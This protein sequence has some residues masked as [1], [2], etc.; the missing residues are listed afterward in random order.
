[1]EGFRAAH[2]IGCAHLD[3]ERLH[4]THSGEFSAAWHRLDHT[5]PKSFSPSSASATL[6]AWFSTRDDPGRIRR[7]PEQQ[8]E[9]RRPTAARAPARGQPPARP[10]TSTC[11]RSPSTPPSAPM[12][13]DGKAECRAR[14]APAAGRSTACGPRS[15]SRAPIRTIARRRRSRSMPGSQQRARTTS[16]PAWRTACTNTSGASTAA[17]AGSTTMS[18]SAHARAGARARRGAGRATNY[19]GGRRDQRGGAARDRRDVPAGHRRDVH[20]ALSHAA[21][22]AGDRAGARRSPP[23]R[24]QR[25]AGWRARH[26]ARL[27]QRRAAR[28][29]L[30]RRLPDRGA[31]R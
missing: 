27:R 9:T 18:T 13:I 1:M 8:P 15:S 24:R 17:A 11:W 5:R 14:C 16:C 19:P 4:C 20:A 7:R 26:A 21:R 3:A 2:Y 22:L 10:S 25:R 30:R 6:L 12:G 31:R 23:V 29:G 28:P